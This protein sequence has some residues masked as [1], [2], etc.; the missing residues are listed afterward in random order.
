MSN[1]RLYDVVVVEMSKEKEKLWRGKDDAYWFYR[2]LEEVG[3]LGTSL[4]NDHDHPP[5]LELCQIGSICLNWLD[6]RCELAKEL[7]D[8]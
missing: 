6:K 7:G 5:E 8:D 2:L 4:A 1:S 3:E